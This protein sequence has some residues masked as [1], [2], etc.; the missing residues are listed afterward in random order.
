MTTSLDIAH[1]ALGTGAAVILPNPAPLTRLGHH[2]PRLGQRPK[3]CRVAHRSH[4]PPGSLGHHPRIV[5][6][7]L[8]RVWALI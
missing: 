1:T 4:L 8:P 7:L 2:Q 5:Y 3:P 6:Y